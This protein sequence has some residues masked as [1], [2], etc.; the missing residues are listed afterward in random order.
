MSPSRRADWPWERVGLA[1][2]SSSLADAA[3]STYEHRTTEEGKCLY[4]AA[5]N[6][7]V[8]GDLLDLISIALQQFPCISSELTFINMCAGVLPF[9]C[10]R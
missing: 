7:K 3:W 2:K 8:E 10:C 1:G 4:E 5:G 6:G 9:G